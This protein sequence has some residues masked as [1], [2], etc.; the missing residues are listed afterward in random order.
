[1]RAYYYTEIVLQYLCF[2]LQQ[3]D[4]NAAIFRFCVAIGW[5]YCYTISELH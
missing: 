3:G 5:E 4:A 2:V 1:M